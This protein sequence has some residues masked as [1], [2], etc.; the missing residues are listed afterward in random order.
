MGFLS[1]STS[2]PKTAT[3]FGFLGPMAPQ[4]MVSLPSALYTRN[5]M[6]LLPLA[7]WAQKCAGFTFPQ[8]GFSN[9]C[10]ICLR[11]TR[12]TNISIGFVSLGLENQK[13][14]VPLFPWPSGPKQILT[15]FPLALWTQTNFDLGLLSLSLVSQKLVGFVSLSLAS[16]T[17]L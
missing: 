17:L 11:Q 14:Y 5:N 3:R 4:K 7:S 12:S 10:W 13:K 6:S 15:L 1:P 16:P 8:P 9:T 2:R